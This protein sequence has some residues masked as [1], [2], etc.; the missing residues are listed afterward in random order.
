METLRLI[1]TILPLALTS[2]INLYATILVAALSIQLK[3]VPNPPPGLEG[4]GSW[5]VVGIAGFF[6]LLEFLA[7]KIPLIDNIWDVIHTFIRP[8]GAGLVAFAVMVELDPVAAVIAA[9]AG[10]SLALVSHTGKT[11]TRMVMNVTSPAENV[12]NIV[13]SA[14]EDVGAGL[15]AFLAL[16]FPYAGLVVGLILLAAIILFVPRLISWGWY[17]LKAIWASISG[18]IFPIEEPEP[19]PVSHRVA[20]RH[21]LPEWSASCKAQ[22]V[23]AIS[24]RSGYLCVQGPDLVFTYNGWSKGRTW[25]IPLAQV[26]G[27]YLRHRLLLDVLEVHFNDGKKDRS[28]RFAFLKDRSLLLEQL[29]QQLKAAEV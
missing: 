14:V 16:R 26:A 20:L 4:L 8:L 25:R 11:G 2:G 17:N 9:L 24:G 1:S 3:W 5:W 28:A 27:A 13:V 10:G 19:L 7:D 12:S 23:P 6:Y 15:L 22:G 29:A 21:V 18:M